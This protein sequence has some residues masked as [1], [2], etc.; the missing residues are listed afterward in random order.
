MSQSKK[1]LLVED[2]SIIALAEANTIRRFG[3]EIVIANSGEGAIRLAHEDASIGLILM[4]ID[5]GRGIDGTE[6][7]KRIL[8]ERNLPIVFLTSHSERE[9]VEKVRGIT[10]YGYIIKN[11]GDFVLQSSI[12]MAFELFESSERTR[13]K[14]EALL[15]EQYLLQSLL[16]NV[17]DYIYFKDRESRF[18]RASRA[19]AL[20]FG[21][22][23]PMLLI[24]KT[25]F[26]FFTEEH[27]RQA[28]EDEQ[29][30]VRTGRMM[31]KEEKETR[32]DQ[33][34]AWVL[35]VKLPL[36]NKQGDIVGTLG[37]SRDI[38]ERK[39]AEE[40]IEFKDRLYATLSSI[41]RTIVTVK[42]RTDLFARV[43][44]IVVDTGQFR[45]AWIGI[46]N[47]ADQT[48]VR[49]TQKSMQEH[50]DLESRSE[51]LSSISLANSPIG[52][53]ITRGKVV[54]YEDPADRGRKPTLG[55][56]LRSSAVIPF[57]AHG[58]NIGVLSI[59]TTESGFFSS[60]ERDLLEEIGFDISLAL[61]KMELENEGGPQMR[62]RS[63]D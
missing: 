12:E 53:A 2:E 6:A 37:I 52:A 48:I 19:L 49:V 40:R 58:R 36:L 7:A 28:Y 29:E 55:G 57:G 3:Y 39:H 59:F 24:G 32:N 21:I 63:T 20:S 45:M 46:L 23:D 8:A 56:D 33:P 43:C 11:S 1:L 9:M 13:E 50:D 14:G 34:D 16:E 62:R 54:L 25:D 35:T 42:E 30:I 5:L 17:P 26:D 44:E 61:E 18:I 4:D 10:R 51:V 60:E 27:A 47:E 22:S 38:T 41:N 31:S 15:K